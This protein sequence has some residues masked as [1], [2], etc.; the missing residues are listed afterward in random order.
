M[1]FYFADS[2]TFVIKISYESNITDNLLI[3]IMQ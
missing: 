2:Y 1:Q 3:N